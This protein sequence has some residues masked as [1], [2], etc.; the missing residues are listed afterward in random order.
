MGS[1][2]GV[3]GGEPFPTGYPVLNRKHIIYPVNIEEYCD[4]VC[5]CPAFGRSFGVIE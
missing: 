5:M 3:G 1:G 2:Q 4:S